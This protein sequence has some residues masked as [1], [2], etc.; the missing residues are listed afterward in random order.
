MNKKEIKTNEE[1][2][3][4]KKVLG[5]TLIALIVT[6][7]IMLILAAIVINIA[8][9]NNG[10]LGRAQ[11]AVEKYKEA[12]ENEQLQI[13]SLYK[14]LAAYNTEGSMNVTE[15]TSLVKQ[16]VEQERLKQYPVGSIYISESD[17][18]PGDFIGGK[19]EKYAN[20]RTLVGEGTSDKDFEVG[21]TGGES[22]HTLTEAEMPAHS[23]NTGVGHARC[24]IPG[25]M[26]NYFISGWA[27]NTGGFAYTYDN[28]IST[29][30]KG[31]NSSHNNLQPY[32]TV[33]MW[34][35]VE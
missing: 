30:V 22:T 9:G 6:I 28:G 5:V 31:S 35:R 23:H 1:V 33:Y 13:N 18:N 3:I 8:L 17:T 14:Q 10:L 32:I 24:N 34:K 2:K 26:D 12:S 21:E 7:I 19:W 16:I 15:M 11:N 27:Y 29:N 4:N 25:G 20:G